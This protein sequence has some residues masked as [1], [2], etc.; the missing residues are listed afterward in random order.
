MHTCNHGCKH[1]EVKYCDDCG[2]TH[3]I[4]CGK[5]WGE[6][7]TQYVPYYPITYPTYPEITWGTTSNLPIEQNV[8]G[9]EIK[10][11]AAQCTYISID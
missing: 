8:V 9:N 5:E 1:K 3:C 11:D 6:K 10:W 4:S 7:D 2:K